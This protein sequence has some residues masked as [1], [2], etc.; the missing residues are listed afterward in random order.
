[1]HKRLFI[2]LSFLLICIS[3]QAQKW[4][5]GF[6]T[7]VKG[8]RIPGEIRLQTGRGPIQGEAYIQ[9]RETPKADPIKLSASDLRSF[10][11][12]RDSFV[13]AA[14][15]GWSIYEL[16]FVRVALDGPLKLYQAQG[17]DLDNTGIGIE[18]G[19]G[20]GVGGGTGGL[21]AGVGGGVSI[22]IGGGVGDRGS[23]GNVY[24][25][26]TNTANMKPISN[27]EFVDIMSEVMGD[28]PDAVEQIRNNQYSL[29]NVEKLIAYF[30]SLEA[31][32]ATK[33]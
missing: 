30:K 15:G 1:M 20:I 11:I 6:F 5:K 12:G 14:N 21:G 25:Y 18:P 24:F 7:D 27:P 10:T 4:Q 33:Q 19:V 28:E 13:V 29:K 26:G 23:K 17:Y 8:S 32:S 16:D 22:P 2:I 3:V 31:K 9:Y